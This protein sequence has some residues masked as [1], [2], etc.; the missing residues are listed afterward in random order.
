MAAGVPLD[1]GSSCALWNILT[2]VAG[3]S[4][5]AL[6]AWFI[7]DLRIVKADHKALDNRV[8]IIDGMVRERAAFCQATSANVGKFMER[9][10]NKLDRLIE[11]RMKNA[12]NGNGG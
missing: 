4:V 6:V 12:E 9:I 3:F 1:G 11:G 7:Y 10:E 8:D 5:A 2:G